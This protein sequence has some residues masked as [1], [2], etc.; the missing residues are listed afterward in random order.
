MFSEFA[1]DRS[2]IGMPVLVNKDVEDSQQLVNYKRK[3]FKL[4]IAEGWV[5]H[6]CNLLM[7]KGEMALKIET[8]KLYTG[9]VSI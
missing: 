5:V 3:S 9:S 1:S 7:R 8:P 2:G 4:Y 6:V